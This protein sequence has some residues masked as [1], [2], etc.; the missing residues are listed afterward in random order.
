[1]NLLNIIGAQ[2]GRG[3]GN[4]HDSVMKEQL[5]INLKTLRILVAALQKDLSTLNEKRLGAI[6]KQL[7]LLDSMRC[8][9][10]FWQRCSKAPNSRKG[11]ADPLN[12]HDD[13]SISHNHRHTD[14]DL[15]WNETFLRLVAQHQRHQTAET[16]QARP[17]S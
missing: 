7:N 6:T 17:T 5:Y 3:F 10:G 9:N 16:P 8:C 1:V 4:F 11:N 15:T 2:S 12:S 13:L 14:C